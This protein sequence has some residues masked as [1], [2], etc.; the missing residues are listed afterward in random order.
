MYSKFS[1]QVYKK[2]PG[3]FVESKLKLEKWGSLEPN[4]SSAEKNK[5][6]M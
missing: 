5:R 3:G 6:K 2:L 4:V 1:T